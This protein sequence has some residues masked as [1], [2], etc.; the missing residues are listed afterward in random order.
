VTRSFQQE[1]AEASDT[2]DPTKIQNSTDLPDDVPKGVSTEQI[3]ATVNKAQTLYELLGAPPTATRVE[4]KKCYVE[5]AKLSHP[6]AQIANSAYSSSN[7]NNNNDDDIPD[8]GEIAAAWRVLGDSKTRKRYDRDLRAK[9][10]SEYAQ[11][12]ANE[13]LERAVPAV[14]AMMDKVAVPFLR[15]TTATTWAVGQAVAKGVTQMSQKPMNGNNSEKDQNK[16]IAIA[17]ALLNAIQAGQQAGRVIDTIELNEKS[18]ELQER[19]VNVVEE[20]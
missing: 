8:F 1:G 16:S 2:F 11:R 7:G 6:D 4:L 20:E 13:R 3:E 14:A 15:R 12:F 9:E 18:L 5:L 10:F 19:S 17:D